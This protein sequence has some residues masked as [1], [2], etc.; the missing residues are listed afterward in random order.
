MPAWP[1]TIVLVFDGH[2]DRADVPSLCGRVTAQL[3]GSGAEV[4]LCD[5]GALAADAAAVDV[6]ARIRLAARRLGREVRLRDASDELRQLLAFTGLAEVLGLEPSGQ[7]EQGEQR[8]G[9]E[10]EGELADPAG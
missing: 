6:L 8:V 4:A 7:P 5:V 1:H 3:E 2:V 9:V 10:E